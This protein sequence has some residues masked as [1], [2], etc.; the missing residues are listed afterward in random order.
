MDAPEKMA[1]ANQGVELVP[2]PSAERPFILSE[3]LPP[4]PFKLTVRILHGEYV[5]MAKLLCNNLEAQRRAPT[6]SAPGN[7]LVVHRSRR[8]VPDLVQGLVELGTVFRHVHGGGDKQVPSLHQ[9]AAGVPDL[10]CEG[11]EA[12]WWEGMLGV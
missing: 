8:E 3:G 1:G 11:G 9:G 12:L 4:I 2:R 6:T 7:A 10:D 5:D